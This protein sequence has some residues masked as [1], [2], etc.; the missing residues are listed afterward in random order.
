MKSEID[1]DKLFKDTGKRMSDDSMSYEKAIVK[2]SGGRFKSKRR[3]KERRARG[4]IAAGGWW[5]EVWRD[6]LFLVAMIIAIY[7]TVD[8]PS[9]RYA[10]AILVV[11]LYVRL[12]SRS[13]LS[14][15]ALTKLVRYLIL[16]S[17]LVLMAVIEIMILD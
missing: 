11:L 17:V 2:E 12:T 4:R 6:V 7:L 13:D 16:T 5:Q 8:Q 3:L 1:I 15:D 9:W 14:R 10:A